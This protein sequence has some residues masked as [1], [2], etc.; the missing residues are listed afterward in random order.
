[1]IRPKILFED[2]HLVVLAKPAGLLSQG[3]R[4]GDENLVDWLRGRFGRGYVGLVHRLDRNTSGLMVV[5]KRTKSANRLTEALRSGRLERAYLAWVHGRVAAPARWRHFLLKDE[6]AN[7]SRAVREGTP[8]AREAV[9]S[10]R[11]VRGARF[12][13]EEVTLV[14]LALETG[15]SHQIR[16]QAAAEGHPLLGDRKYGARDT[17]ARVALHSHRLSFPHPM[18]GE[19]MSFEEALPPE[20]RL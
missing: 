4:T 11:P 18:S 3:E 9:L 2:T 5:A 14:E 7:R 19:T 1:V 20:L 13:D 6:A 8:G 16:A 17:F 15:R 10:A 12:G